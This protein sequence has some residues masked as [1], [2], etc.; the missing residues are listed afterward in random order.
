MT[1]TNQ[2][3]NALPVVDRDA[4]WWRSLEELAGTEEFEAHIDQHDARAG[5]LRR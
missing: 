3:P 5:R 2:R 1:S 4:S